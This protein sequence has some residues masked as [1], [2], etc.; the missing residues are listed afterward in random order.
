MCC[1][2][3]QQQS[4]LA[5]LSAIDATTKLLSISGLLPNPGKTVK[6]MLGTPPAQRDEKFIN[7]T[8]L[9]VKHCL[10]F[11]AQLLF[12]AK[13]Y[14]TTHLS[15]GKETIE[16]W[17]ITYKNW[18]NNPEKQTDETIEKNVERARRRIF[19]AVKTLE[20]LSKKAEINIK[21]INKQN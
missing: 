10:F 8:I 15:F 18:I 6:N 17:L 4:A 20:E 16:Q 5:S 19:F 7:L 21:T 12:H 2:A 14:K 11:L 1:L 9:S 3:F 13:Y